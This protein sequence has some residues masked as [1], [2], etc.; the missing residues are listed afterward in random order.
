MTSRQAAAALRIGGYE[1]GALGRVVELHGLYYAAHW[2]FGPYF[3]CKVAAGVAEFLG[4]F[5]PARDGFWLA[6]REGRIVGSITIDGAPPAADAGQDDPAPG[7]ARLRWFIVEPGL[8]GQGAGGVLMTE[9]MDFC[10]RAGFRRV[11][12][13]TF[14][15]LD[16]ARRLY[17]RHGFV[18]THEAEDTTWGTP[19]LEQCFEWTPAAPRASASPGQE[20]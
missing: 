5:D 15:G 14:A 2:G 20:G 17:E 18:L 1:P 13:T 9:A 19:V 16:A 3:E 10:R 4:R 8:Q 12:L 6:R 7:T 11:Y